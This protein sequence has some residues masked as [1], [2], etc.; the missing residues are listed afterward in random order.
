MPATSRN[1]E[2]R[3]SEFEEAADAFRAAIAVT[4]SDGPSA[5]MLARSTAFALEP[6]PADVTW[7]GVWNYHHK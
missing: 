1:W 5:L 2:N 4:G 3:A 7:E 6:P